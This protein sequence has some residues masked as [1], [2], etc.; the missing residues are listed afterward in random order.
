[1]NVQCPYS[2]LKNGK[3]YCHII[4]TYNNK[5]IEDPYSCGGGGSCLGKSNWPS[6]KD[7]RICKYYQDAIRQKKIREILK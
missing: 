2:K 4:K 1:M 5:Y 3:Y 7:K 6:Y